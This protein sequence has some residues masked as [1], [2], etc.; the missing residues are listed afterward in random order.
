MFNGIPFRLLPCCICLLAAALIALP[1]VD[2][3]S[4]PPA[5]S[6]PWVQ[7]F[8]DDFN[9]TALDTSKWSTGYGWGNITGF[10]Q[11]Y[12]DPRNVRVADGK[13]ISM[14]PGGDDVAFG[15][16]ETAIAPQISLVLLVGDG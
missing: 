14:D 15:S 11:E 4:G 7:T 6:G 2:P 13:L 10:S 9:G 8:S 5:G 3:Q 1:A 12:A 16:K